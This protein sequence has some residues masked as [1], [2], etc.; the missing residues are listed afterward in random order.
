MLA[1]HETTGK[2]LRALWALHVIGGL[3]EARLH[4]LLKD[5]DQHIRAFAIQFL[6]EDKSPSALT[7]QKFE[8]LAKSDRSP[9]VRLYLASALQ[10]LPHEQRWPILAALSQHAEDTED[11]NIPRMLWFA[12]EPMV[13]ANPEKSLQLVMNSKLTKLQ[14]LTAR[15]VVSGD[16]PAPRARKRDTRPTFPGNAPVAHQKEIQKVAPGFQAWDLGLRGAVPHKVFRNEFA[17]M[18]HPFSREKPAR[19][20]R[21]LEVPEGKTTKLK[22]RVSHH[23]HAD[24][25]L[26]VLAGKKLLKDTMV[27][28]KT[29]GKDEWLN[30][31]FDLTDYAGQHLD[32][33]LEC[34]ANNWANEWAYWS[35][36]KVVSN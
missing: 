11:N 19:L 8:E 28:S 36:A 5:K 6:M 32:L 26:R 21:H 31:E 3:D 7:L 12:L 27:S 33:T 17:I 29:V 10:R 16:L 13:P 25:Q 24:W 23:P 9:V 4:E 15:R 18:T 22:L 2:A 34:E 20:M 14:Q 1:T 35:Q 30:L